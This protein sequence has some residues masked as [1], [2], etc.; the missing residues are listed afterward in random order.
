[1]KQTKGINFLNHYI[2]DYIVLFLVIILLVIFWNQAIDKELSA[3]PIVIYENSD[4]KRLEGELLTGGD[5]VSGGPGYTLQ[6]LGEGCNP[7]EQKNKLPNLPGFE[8][9][10]PCDS[11]QGL[12][13]VQGIVEGGGICLKNINRECNLKNDCVPQADMCLYGFCQQEGEVINKPCIKNSDC[14]GSNGQNF[15]HVCDP[16]SKRCKFDTF[17]RDSGCALD[18]Q[19]VFYKDIPDQNEAI[20][21]NKNT[22]FSVTGTFS[23]SGNSDIIT[24]SKPPSKLPIKDNFYIGVATSPSNQY[25]GRYYVQDIKPSGT[26]SSIYFNATEFNEISGVTEYTLS[27]GGESDGIC[28]ITM[29]AGVQVFNVIPDDKKLK[30]PCDTNLKVLSD[31]N[32]KS[33]CVE[34]DRENILGKIGEVCNTVGLGCESGLSCAY[35]P[36]YETRLNSNKN[37]F[38]VEGTDGVCVKV[39]GNATEYQAIDT[40]GKC[41]REVA[42]KDERCDYEA[43]GCLKPNICLQQ[44]DVNKSQLNYCGR[45][46]DV[47]E[48]TPL[49]GCPK[50][51]TISPR[52]TDSTHVYE[53]LSDNLKTCINS[54]DCLI[55]SCGNNHSNI[56]FYSFDDEQFKTY[57]NYSDFQKNVSHDSNRNN[58]TDFFISNGTSQNNG[59]SPGAM[60]VYNF[61]NHK[62]NMEIFFNGSK[63]SKYERTITFEDQT[64]EK[65]KISI[66]KKENGKHQLNIIYLDK[67]ENYNRRNYGVSINGSEILINLDF[68]LCPSADIFIERYDETAAKPP[69]EIYNIDYSKST[70]SSVTGY[71][72]I[73]N[74]LVRK[75]GTGTSFFPSSFTDSYQL[76]SYDCGYKFNKNVINKPQ[77]F[78]TNNI[79]NDGITYSSN[80]DTNYPLT[81]YK[82]GNSNDISFTTNSG[83][84]PLVDGAEYYYVRPGDFSA[85]ALMLTDVKGDYY[86]VPT[87]RGT[88]ISSINMNGGPAS[89]FTNNSQYLKLKTLY[90]INIYTE[91]IDEEHIG[92]KEITIN[93]RVNYYQIP[94][95]IIFNTGVKFNQPVGF[96]TDKNSLDNYSV[97]VTEDKIIVSTNLDKL[98]NQTVQMTYGVSDK[99]DLTKYS[100]KIDYTNVN[101]GVFTY[102]NYDITNSYSP[103][104]PK[105]FSGTSYTGNTIDDFTYPYEIDR[106]MDYIYPSPTDNS[107]VDFFV[108]YKNI[109]SQNYNR[110]NIA[111]EVKLRKLDYDYKRNTL[112]DL[113]YKGVNQTISNTNNYSIIES[114]LVPVTDS[115]GY[116]T[117]IAMSKI[118]ETG[119]GG[120]I[121][122]KNYYNINGSNI[123]IK[124]QNDIDAILKYSS[125]ELVIGFK[126]SPYLGTID[127]NSKTC[128]YFIAITGII[129][130]D[131]ND[132]LEETLV[133]NTNVFITASNLT[134]FTPYLFV[135]NIVP[136]YVNSDSKTPDGSLIVTS[137]ISKKSEIF[138]EVNDLT[139]YNKLL[140]PTQTSSATF[141]FK[142]IRLMEGTNFLS[143]VGISKKY[144]S[145]PNPNP[146]G[147]DLI[148]D[149]ATAKN[150]IVY[151]VNNLFISSLSLSR[152]YLFNNL[153]F[154]VSSV[155][156]IKF[157]FSEDI[158]KGDTKL[159]VDTIPFY[160]GFKTLQGS[161]D[162]SYKTLFNW[163]FWITTLN[164]SNFEFYKMIVNF[165]PGNVENDMF[166]YAFVKIGGVPMLLYLST[167]LTDS[168]IIESTP[169][170]LKLKSDFSSKDAKTLSTKMS[171]TPYDRR[172]YS[173]LGSCINN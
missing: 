10:T 92:P 69:H 82:N 164:T 27:L 43:R 31:K 56:R 140:Y 172:L 128:N 83:P 33:F 55:N 133:L 125:S 65:P 161:L 151:L 116:L 53:C 130:Y 166:Y 171:M 35:N 167:N 50:N 123:V 84:C 2:F 23:K 26:C 127:S 117:P 108:N 12:V 152:Y 136:I 168:S 8:I 154:N 75:S 15:N 48:A 119:P 135:N 87:I 107:T 36:E 22:V 104:N 40:I 38:F 165:N 163:P 100:N 113:K 169:I 34:Q 142:D 5:E 32:G 47:M 62:V 45:N 94:S 157:T 93:N 3:P 86:N 146:I 89:Q 24:V 141:G 120:Q 79:S 148:I 105:I 37:T 60:G 158:R 81:Y 39:I 106:V 98:R 59:I 115:F 20:C 13:C 46:W 61:V 51:Y 129:S 49:I 30:F 111:N 110:Y 118:E 132:S 74:A 162:Q 66:F 17:P 101:T 1:M 44:E 63:N 77:N 85:N 109:E 114:L 95:D 139:S 124:N 19:C 57:I 9:R 155:K 28:L 103:P 25:V 14:T 76:I 42:K 72:N 71:I 18:S 122:G 52:V 29:P 137:I 21:L 131:I 64:I 4:K 78:V 149:N 112:I 58:Y 11:K 70:A 6:G 150:R 102:I 138:D 67:Y 145:N 80:L 144:I 16:E 134:N 156:F 173:F 41:I 73:R 96:L 121:D 143:T 88:S 153:S 7:T 68:G 54:S 90:G 160:N 147:I 99:V 97:E 126:L 159:L 91:E 170:P